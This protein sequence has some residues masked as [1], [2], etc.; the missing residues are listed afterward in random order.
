MFQHSS[1]SHN[2]N[3]SSTRNVALVA[4]AAAAIGAGLTALFTPKSGK[5]TRKA[6]SEG[7]KNVELQGVKL[8]T[9]A[10]SKL[11]PQAKK[12]STK[13]TKAAQ[14]NRTSATKKGTAK[15]SKQSDKKPAAKK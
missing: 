10:K 7:A 11:K 12:T 8:A 9:S 2:S 13:L 4:V 14:T 3:V 6:I 5:E 1:K 15:T